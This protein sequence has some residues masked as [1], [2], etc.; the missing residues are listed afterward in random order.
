MLRALR[1]IVALPSRLH[2]RVLSSDADFVRG[3]L[4]AAVVQDWGEN[5]HGTR[6][7]MLQN[8]DVPEVQLAQIMVSSGTIVHAAST[9][10]ALP[11]AAVTPLVAHILK[12]ARDQ[13][14]HAAAAL[15]GLCEWV[16]ALPKEALESEFGPEAAEAALAVANGQPRPGH[17][18]LGQGTFRAAAPAWEPLATRFAATEAAE[19]VQFYRSLGATDVSPR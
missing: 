8:P 5:E 15:P 7:L 10:D 9:H 6:V 4:P 18:V 12:E 13:T 14:V 19:E 2:A 17:Q 16:A 11:I 1:R 3:L